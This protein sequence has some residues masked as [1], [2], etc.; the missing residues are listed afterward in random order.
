MRFEE[1]NWM[2]VESYLQNDDRVIIIL[3]ACEQ[4]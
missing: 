4:H 2:D 1:I 3:G